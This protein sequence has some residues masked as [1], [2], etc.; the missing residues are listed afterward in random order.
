M[1]TE[2]GLACRHH[3]QA[4]SH[5]STVHSFLLIRLITGEAGVLLM[6]ARA[7]AAGQ[8]ERREGLVKALLPT[9]MLGKVPSQGLIVFLLCVCFLAA[10]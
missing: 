6:E 2:A 8:M 9:P 7:G 1:S 3:T 5:V 10:K 4:G